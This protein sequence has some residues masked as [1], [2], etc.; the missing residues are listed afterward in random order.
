[1]LST[2]ASRMLRPMSS[3]SPMEARA[4]LW[5]RSSWRE[6]SP[7]RTPAP[8]ESPWVLR[9]WETAPRSRSDEARAGAGAVHLDIL[10]FAGAL[11]LLFFIT[12]ILRQKDVSERGLSAKVSAKLDAVLTLAQSSLQTSNN[13]TIPGDLGFDCTD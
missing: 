12:F 1:M 10:L 6:D 5:G 13:V 3:S 9:V 11:I 7:V 2:T 8:G 4:S